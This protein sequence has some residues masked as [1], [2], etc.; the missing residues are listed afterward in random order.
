MRHYAGTTAIAALFTLIVAAAPTQAQTVDDIVARHLA[1]RG[2]AE[3]WRTIESQRTTGTVYTQGIELAMVLTTKRPN[4]SRQELTLDIPG[5]GPVPIINVFDGTK[6]WTV[7]PML[8]GS[9]AMELTGRDAENMR[10]QSEMDSPLIDYKA[11]GH[12]VQLI[13]TETV[14]TRRAHRL[15]VTRPGRTATDYFID[16]ETGV[17]L[18][19][20]SDTVDSAVV[21]FSDHRPIGGGLV[22]HLIRIQQ[23]GQPEVEVVVTAVEFNVPTTDAMFRRP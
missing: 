6:A 2:G 22:P 12:G 4:L 8:G 5:Q 17:E 15:K 23:A 1:S 7:N 19:I 18:R 3:T 21:E 10:D 14:G 13:G 11:K 9:E 20:T 16:A